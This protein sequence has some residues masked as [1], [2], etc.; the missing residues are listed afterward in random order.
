MSRRVVVDWGFNVVPFDPQTRR[1][2]LWGAVF[3]GALT[4]TA[5]AAGIWFAGRAGLHIQ[6]PPSEIL[7]DFWEV[8]RG[9]PKAAALA[10]LAALF[11][12]L[13]GGWTFWETFKPREIGIRHMRGR[14]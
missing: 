9:E 5:T 12:G 4:A 13:A 3:A 2:N 6:T 14:R 8:A 11:G 7:G 10:S 1:R